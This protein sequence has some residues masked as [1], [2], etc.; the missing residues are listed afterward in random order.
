MEAATAEDEIPS[1]WE[2][3]SY[4]ADLK[5]SLKDDKMI[6]ITNHLK[7]LSI[8]RAFRPDRLQRRMN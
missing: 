3:A 1:G 2:N 6:L 8:L 5:N 4:E 7:D